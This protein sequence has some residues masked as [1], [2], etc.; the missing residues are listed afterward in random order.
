MTDYNYTPDY[1]DGSLTRGEA[2]DMI[3]QCGNMDDL[4]ALHHLWVGHS[5]HGQT[6]PE[7]LVEYLY[8]YVRDAC[9]DMDG[10]AIRANGPRDSDY[11][12]ISA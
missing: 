4:E 3:A 6:S 5:Q 2:D 7:T 11:T 1:N 10:D 12:G 8:G 9:M